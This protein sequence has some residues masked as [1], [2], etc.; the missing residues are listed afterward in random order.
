MKKLLLSIILFIIAI[1]VISA[2]TASE[3]LDKAASKINSAKSITAEY[4]ISAASNKEKGTLIL[5]S[6]KFTLTSGSL[7]SWFDGLT[8]WT[9][10]P[11]MGE[12][13]IT[14]PTAEELADINPFAVINAHK[15]NYRSALLSSE[16]NIYKI[17]LTPVK[18]GMA[19]SKATVIL[20]AATYL[21][22][23]II[24]TMPDKSKIEIA[25]DKVTAGNMINS[26][27]FVF[28]PSYAP[29]AEIVDLR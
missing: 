22:K 18:K 9:Y 26:P 11:A 4:T 8:L 7:R 29:D 23:E 10:S 1:P 15:Q 21:P 14:N 25:I 5:A 6:G 27:T 2:M 19:F 17:D 3:I 12:V 16:K 20:D 28:D 13:N 24:L